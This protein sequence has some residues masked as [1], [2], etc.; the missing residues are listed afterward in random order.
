MWVQQPHNSLVTWKVL[1][2]VNQ[3][4][5]KGQEFVLLVWR[6]A[7]LERTT[8]WQHRTLTQKRKQTHP[9]WLRKPLFTSGWLFSVSH[10]I[11]FYSCYF[12]VIQRFRSCRARKRTKLQ[13]LFSLWKHYRV[14]VWLSDLVIV[15][16]VP[17]IDDFKEKKIKCMRCTSV[18][19]VTD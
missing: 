12:S 1:K 19:M 14:F 11:R 5:L 18:P 9:R 3:S 6:A 15:M 10:C 16:R 13:L 4:K 17:I 8:S 7:P 2:V